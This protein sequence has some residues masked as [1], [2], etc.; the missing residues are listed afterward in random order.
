MINAE[1][2]E[3]PEITKRATKQLGIYGKNL[4]LKLI[5]ELLEKKMNSEPEPVFAG[6]RN[7]IFIDDSTLMIEDY[8]SERLQ[9][10]ERLK[11]LIIH[12]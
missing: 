11:N 6:F 9:N 5:N 4:V 10:F 12:E 1:N 8:P 7:S 2:G 3:E